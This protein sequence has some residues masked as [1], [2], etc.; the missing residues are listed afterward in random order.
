[1][2]GRLVPE[3]FKQ[4]RFAPLPAC[5]TSFLSLHY[6]CKLLLYLWGA[7][8]KAAIE[9]CPAGIEY[10]EHKR[11]GPRGSRDPGDGTCTSVHAL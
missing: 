5:A 4:K 1:M 7:G 9:R 11:V 6:Y 8:N 2:T 3:R 10:R